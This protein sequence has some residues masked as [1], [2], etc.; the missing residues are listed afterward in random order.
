[1]ATFKLGRENR[2]MYDKLLLPDLPSRS[3]QSPLML[4]YH[5]RKFLSSTF[6]KL[7]TARQG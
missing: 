7:S 5:Q 3:D 4:D 2:A 1:M 6:L